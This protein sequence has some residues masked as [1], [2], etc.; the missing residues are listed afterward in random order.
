[1]ITHEVAD[2]IPPAQNP[3]MRVRSGE[4]LRRRLQGPQARFDF[5]V[6]HDLKARATDYF[7][8]PVGG[9]FGPRVCMAAYVTD[10]PGGFSER[11][12]ADLSAVS[13][14][15]SIVADMNSARDRSR[16]TSSRPILDRRPDGKCWPVKSGAAAA[17]RSPPCFGRRTFASRKCLISSPASQGR[18]GEVLADG[19][20]VAANPAFSAT[21]GKPEF[22][23]PLVLL[24]GEEGL[25]P[26]KS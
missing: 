16:K 6:L 4:I 24:V 5:S 7:A 12:I 15:L 17:K 19:S 10:R 13:E 26:S 3:V 21:T 11:E 23:K 22:K 20:R 1:M 14:R 8:L 9:A 18:C 25:E 2:L